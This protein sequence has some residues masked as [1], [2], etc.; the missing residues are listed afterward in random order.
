MIMALGWTWCFAAAGTW[1]RG[2][3]WLSVL[4]WGALGI[5]SIG[6]LLPAAWRP[7]P[8]VVGA[9]NGVGFPLL[10]I[11][12]IA[13][14]ERVL[15]LPRPDESHGRMAPWRCPRAGL[16]GRAI[17][18]ISNSRFLRALCEWLPLVALNSDITD[19]IYVNYLV[20]AQQLLPLVPSGLELQRLGPGGRWALFTLLTYRHGHFGPGLLGPL[21]QLLPSPVQS[22]WRIYVA[23]RKR[24]WK[25]FTS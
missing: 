8:V 6:L 18:A 20:D 14:T 21:R 4:A 16:L 9:A 23:I 10:L 7:P 19:V 12:L 22:N 15:R 24:V 1:S 3:T 17:D 2:L 5:G 25:G 13:V 11:W